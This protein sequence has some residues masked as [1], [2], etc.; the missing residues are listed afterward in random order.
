[1]KKGTI[2]LI[3]LL[4]MVIGYSA[5]NTTIN[6]YGNSKI[7]ENISDFKVYISSLK[8]NGNEVSGING[9]KDGFEL[10]NVFGTIEYEITNNSTEY[11]TEA[12]LECTSIKNETSKV[13]SYDYTG[14]E[15]TFIAP[16]TGTYKLE[17]WGAQGYSVNS[18]YYG[19]YGGYS[20]GNV[21]LS[22]NDKLYI[23][24]GEEGPGGYGNFVSFPN[25]GSGYGASPVYGGAG[26]GSTHILLKSSSLSSLKNE[27]EKILIVSG[28]GGA[29]TYYEGWNGTGGNAGGYKASAGTRMRIDT[30]NYTTG[31]GGS[32]TVGGKTGSCGGNDG[33][34]GLG[35]SISN[36]GGAG[37]GGF[38]GGGGTCGATG[39]GGSGYIGNTLLTNKSMYCYNCSESDEIPTKTIS[40]TCVSSTPTENCAK[41]GNGYARITLVDST[42][43]FSTEKIIVEALSNN[44]KTLENISDKLLTCKLKLNK[45]SRTE[46]KIYTA[47]KVW[48]YDYTGS[49]Q[50]FIVPTAGTYKLETW[51]AQGYSVNS[52]YY[53][54]YGGYS[55]GNVKLSTND[56]LYIYV[57]EE[58][59]GGYGNFMSFPNGGSGYGASPV[60]GGAGG[61]STHILLKS[62]SLSSLKNELEKI[63]IVSGGGG[64][65]TYYEGWNGTGGNAGGYKAS[66]GTRMRIDTGN[67]TTGTGGSQTVGG[68]T[69]SCG[70]NDG[71]FGLGGSI[72]NWGGAG[73]GGFYG[74]GGTCGATGGGG[75]GYIGNTLL[76]NKSMYCYNCSESDEIPTKT[77]STTCVSSTP[78]ENCAKQGNGYARITLIS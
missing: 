73:G 36:W 61:G 67:Y 7:A 77:I 65:S 48:S 18:I 27:L 9:S 45:L 70:G 64:A 32:Q 28:G 68:K 58:G 66:A 76:T 1:M 16:A 30:G 59:P 43:N 5:Y 24:V 49:E 25:G 29:S 20:I 60:Y 41:Q 54:G 33:E 62:S 10:N 51:G 34:F 11:D 53:G 22:T 35:G 23:Y 42:N 56:K 39:G 72:S 26:G 12:S 17:T 6:L 63:L 37:G 75:S 78:T 55:I 14:S 46:K 57:G 13:W 8:V 15:Q 50:T 40:T 69:G 38:Y 19:G 31:T 3:T 52:I 44:N 47:P 4:L 74:G 2:I 21:K 71:E